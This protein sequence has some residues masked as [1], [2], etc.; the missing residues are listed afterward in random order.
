MGDN[1]RRLI[2]FACEGETVVGTVDEADGTI[3]LLIVS[4]GNEIRCGAH[5]GMALLANRLAVQGVPVFRFDRRGVGDSGGENAGYL[6]SRAD[7]VAAGLAFRRE[8]PQL[9]HIMGFGNCDGATALASFGRD[10]GLDGLILANPWVVEREDD[11]PPAAA[12]RSRY[13]QRLRDPA[14]WRAFATGG[15]DF[16]S[17]FKGLRRIVATRSEPEPLAADV[18]A[19]IAAWGEAAHIV[20]AERDST[21]IAYADAARRLELRVPTTLIDTASHSFARGNDTQALEHA[22]LATLHQP[23]N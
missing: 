6:S 14:A 18:I 2:T 9:A 22:V 15:I 19:A 21:A 3:G 16:A 1:M 20:L 8:V 10:A 17:L 7:I 4:G 23:T 5:R 13:L 12:I 11:L